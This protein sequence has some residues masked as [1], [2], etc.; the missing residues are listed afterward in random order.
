MN[1]DLVEEATLRFGRQVH[2]GGH[3]CKKKGRPLKIYTHGGRKP[4]GIDALLW[5]E[6]NGVSRCGWDLLTISWT[7]M[8]SERYALA[9]TRKIA[10]RWCSIPVRLRR[11]G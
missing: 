1:P 4:T 10:D 2:R 9:I 5:A 8:V 3:G 6:K 7:P 11:R